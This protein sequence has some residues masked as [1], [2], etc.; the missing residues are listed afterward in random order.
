[1]IERRT[2]IDYSW[3]HELNPDN[4]PWKPGYRFCVRQLSTRS[5]SRM[6][7]RYY[8]QFR[9]SREGVL[10]WCGGVKATAKTLADVQALYD[11]GRR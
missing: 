1:M 10:E 2:M 6:T 3:E 7:R 11:R 5:T 8:V 4:T 9:I